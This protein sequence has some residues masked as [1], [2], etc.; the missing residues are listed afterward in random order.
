MSFEYWRTLIQLELQKESAS[1]SYLRPEPLANV[2]NINEIKVSKDLLR[3]CNQKLSQHH[4]HKTMITQL[5]NNI[6]EFVKVKI[7]HRESC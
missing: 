1:M 4:L 7:S 5:V 6:S 3:Q 2:L